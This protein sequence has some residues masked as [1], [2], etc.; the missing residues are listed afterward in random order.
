MFIYCGVR[1]TGEILGSW[2]QLRVAW[3]S[4]CV[5]GKV[6]L[7]CIKGGIHLIQNGLS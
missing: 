1:A 6:V 4:V 3:F 2:T 7:F 5:Y